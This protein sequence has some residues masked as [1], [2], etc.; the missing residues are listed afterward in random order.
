MAKETSQFRHGAEAVRWL[1]EYLNSRTQVTAL[2]LEV[3]R[4]IRLCA[5]QE[6]EGAGE[7]VIYLHRAEVTL[8][9]AD[10]SWIDLDGKSFG[11]VC[12]ATFHEGERTR[13]DVSLATGRLSIEFDALQV[14][15]GMVPVYEIRR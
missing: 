1:Q 3:P 14:S 11:N 8:S 15:E 5:S 7:V 6:T 13:L 4:R 2:A 9:G 12:S 10:L